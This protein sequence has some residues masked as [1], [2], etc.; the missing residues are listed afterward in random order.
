MNDRE[1]LEQAM[2]AL[3]AQRAILGDAVVE[4]ALGSIRQ[5]LDALGGAVPSPSPA[6]QRK[7]ATILFADVSSFTA[8]TETLDPEDVANTMNALWQ[9]LDAIIVSH[10]GKIDKH[11]GDGVMALWGSSVSH[12]D[13]PERAIRAA[14]AMRADLQAFTT[15]AGLPLQMRIA[16]NTGPV[17]L[18]AVGTIGES[19]AM[20]DAVNVASRLEQAAPVG[21]ILISHDTYRHVPGLFDIRTQEPLNVKGKGEPIQV[22]LV[23]RTRPRTLRAATRGVEGTETRTIG[24]DAECQRLIETWR[25]TLREQQLRTVLVNADAGVG[26]SRLLYEFRNWLELRAAPSDSFDFKTRAVWIFK[27]RATPEMSR[28]P[29]S[30][31]RDLFSFRFEIQESDSLA[32]ARAKMEQGMFDFMDPLH[33]PEEV[34]M[35]AHFLGHLIGFDF[36]TSSYLRGI[37]PDSKQIRDRAFHY[38]TQFFR[39]ATSRYPAVIYLEDIHWADEGSLD[40]LEH[41]VQSCRDMPLMILCLARPTLFERRPAWAQHQLFHEQIDLLPLSR[42]N[43]QQLV[44]EILRQVDEIPQVLSELIISRAEGNPFYVEELIKMLIEDGVIVKEA[45]AWRVEP[46]RLTSVRVPATLT[47]ILQARLDSLPPLEREVLQK[48]SV[49]GREFWEDA[50][51][52]LHRKSD[53]EGGEMEPGPS[54]ETIREALRALQRRELIFRRDSSAFVNTHEY[55]FKHALLHEVTYETVLR[56]QRRLYHAHAAAWLIEQSGER[57]E[58]YAG[59]IAQH[60]ERAGY[61]TR[62]VEWYERAAAQA[63]ASYAPAAAIDY[64]QKALSFLPAPDGESMSS[65][66]AQVHRQRVMLYE[67]LADALVQQALYSDALQAY[68]AMREAAQAVGD[69]LA[70]ARSWNRTSLVHEDQGAIRIHLESA[71]EA[72]RLLETI[73]PQSDEEQLACRLELAVALHRQGWARYRLGQ[74]E[75]ALQLAEK[76]LAQS[77]EIGPPAQ[78]EAIYAQRLLGVLHMMLGR[79]EAAHRYL[80]QALNAFQ[81]LGD[82][83]WVSRMWNGLGENS[84]LQGDY[85][86]A[87]TCYQSA[88]IIALEIGNRNWEVMYRSNLGGARVGLGEYEEA[89]RELRRAV[90][91]ADASGWG[92]LAETY[93][94]LAQALLGQGRLNEAQ[95]TAHLAMTLSEQT[96]QPEFIGAT[97]RVLGML[98]SQQGRVEEATH[99]F[100][101]SRRIFLE[102]SM[103]AERARTLREWARHERTHGDPDR[104]EAM[105][106]EARATFRNLGMLAELER[107]EHSL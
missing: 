61:T 71:Q 53:S 90:E 8:L 98:A 96:E 6:A 84:R 76:A 79:Y 33:D 106:E 54:L 64:Y 60:Y 63:H 44:E 88:L 47:G 81:A 18:S 93:C 7:Q 59:L 58:E 27:G 77:L 3:E 42:E 23:E 57:V 105:R 74:P 22:Y 66:A 25:T 43:T 75:A 86:A 51:V 92:G 62:V 107:L 68:S 49:I 91:M 30:L 1:Q 48:A 73:E 31:I 97:W 45:K 67:G 102:I 2:V 41:L 24:R 72:E 89:E 87:V 28:L 32:T 11:L 39:A 37:L 69:M 50:V 38:A 14:L 26:K 15:T 16:L 104:A 5:Q 29:Y 95:E 103:G 20:G 65:I 13:D 40:M 83:R 36:S 17:L 34:M 4:A 56:R 10:G 46:L 12:E 9:R 21:G 99:A 85:R 82:R 55:I 52:Y 80:E 35:R 94:F 70:Q 101:E 100:A 19:T 78:R